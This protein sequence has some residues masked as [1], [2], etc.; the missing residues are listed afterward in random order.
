MT[1][2]LVTYVGQPGDPRDLY[3]FPTGAL[4]AAF[5]G[6][7]TT[8]RDA[9]PLTRSGKP[10]AEIIEAPAPVLRWQPVPV[11]HHVPPRIARLFGGE[12]W[13]LPEGVLA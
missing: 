11:D 13:R 5:V 7:M 4:C 1:C 8:W 6:A 2:A 12:V 3:R 10:L 9:D